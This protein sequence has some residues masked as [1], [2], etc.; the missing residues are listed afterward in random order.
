[1][2][3]PFLVPL[4]KWIGQQC[5]EDARKGVKG[6]HDPYTS[7]T[8][9]QYTDG[10]TW[11]D[12]EAYAGLYGGYDT[13]TMQPPFHRLPTHQAQA[14]NSTVA[15]DSI[16]ETTNDL[17]QLLSFSEPDYNISE[18]RQP[19]N[20]PS[21]HAQGLLSMFQGNEYGNSSIPGLGAPSRPLQ[22]PMDQIDVAPP[23][24]KSPHRH[25]NRPP[26][27]SAMAPPPTFPYPQGAPQ[28]Y[29]IPPAARQMSQQAPLPKTSRSGQNA[30]NQNHP[31]R[32]PY[33]RTGDPQF[34]QQFGNQHDRSASIP[35][36]S[37][38]P[39]PKLS[40]HASNLLSAFKSV[41]KVPNINTAVANDHSKG[42]G[43]SQNSSRLSTPHGQNS[44]D[45]ANQA[46]A[47]RES[48]ARFGG[49]IPSS[50]HSPTIRDPKPPTPSEAKR[51]K[52][53]TPK[54]AAK[55]APNNHQTA[56][57]GLIK[58]PALEP[59]NQE[60]PA[61][62]TPAEKRPAHQEAL[63]NLFNTPAA[64]KTSTMNTRAPDDGRVEVNTLAVAEDLGIIDSGLRSTS[65]QKASIAKPVEASQTP[66]K[67]TPAK[68]SRS[69]EGKTE[70]SKGD[71]ATPTAPKIL[72]RP[73]QSPAKDSPRDS[74]QPS[75]VNP[76]PAKSSD[77]PNGS[78]PS[79]PRRK[80]PVATPRVA[81]EVKPSPIK[82]LKRPANEN[83]GSRKETEVNGSA[84]KPFQPQILRR[85]QSPKSTS[86]KAPA[87]EDT[88]GE[89][90]AGRKEA[91]TPEYP[92]WYAIHN[93]SMLEERPTPG[94]NVLTPSTEA[95][96]KQKEDDRPS[97]HVDATSS[98]VQTP[99]LS[100]K[101]KDF[102]HSYLRGVVGPKS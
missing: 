14:D 20:A 76:S 19:T 61:Q 25:Q 57:L 10:D 8:D 53:S 47:R 80:K 91:E 102:L 23:E 45:P 11:G 84:K 27:F 7:A 63:L 31:Q 86:G 89:D 41:D 46:S 29:G 30:V 96:K 28:G 15:L 54:D 37:Q 67:V 64:V 56:L 82:I 58:S 95:D 69:S 72:Q 6:S 100:S 83:Q 97:E 62:E 98:E 39:A 93:P 2:V 51:S 99:T 79:R 73:K 3:A 68:Q 44:P 101:N 78:T 38:L 24:P 70:K 13:D 18:T 94:E 66:S 32:A 59:Q 26:P 33:Q 35:A 87:N 22:T 16:P 71:N 40:K 85:P 12:D 74:P 77:M 34:A 42:Q 17:R 55:F 9:A 48:R 50:V 60:V 36:A 65:A 88:P 43:R 75:A 52:P 21:T 90:S 81:A 49:L 5:R 92:L 1:M 4:K